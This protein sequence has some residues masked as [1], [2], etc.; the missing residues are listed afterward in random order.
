MYHVTKNNLSDVVNNPVH[1]MIYTFIIDSDQMTGVLS[2][3]NLLWDK[4]F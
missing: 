3:R 1:D 4:T 2:V